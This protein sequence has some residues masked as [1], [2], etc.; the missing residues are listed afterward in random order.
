[1]QSAENLFEAIKAGNLSL[2]VSMYREMESEGTV[3]HNGMTPLLFCAYTGALHV[4]EAL[5]EA[6]AMPDLYESIALGKLTEFYRNVHS[7]EA[8]DGYSSDGWTALHLAAFFGDV[9]MAEE[10][11][12]RGANV[13]QVSI[14]PMANTPLHAAI[15]GKNNTRMISFLLAAGADVQARAAGGYTPLHIAAS[16][17]D[18]T[19]VQLLKDKGAT[20]V[21]DAA[22]RLPADIALERGHDALLPLFAQAPAALKNATT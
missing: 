7:F 14:N 6:G 13:M 4:A 17:G 21:A 12:R 19:T 22:G 2:A 9:E 5:I 11:V 18:K 15:A 16:R 3:V 20:E 1:M 8:L 10:L